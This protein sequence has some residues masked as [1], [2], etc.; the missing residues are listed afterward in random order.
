MMD[1]I[2]INAGNTKIIAHRG[3][4]GIE[5]ENTAAA[6]V[7]AGNRP[8]YFGMENDIHRTADGRFVVF[9]DDNTGNLSPVDI[10]V[11]QTSFSELRRLT[12]THRD[13]RQPVHRGDAV[14]PAFEEYLDICACYG[15]VG[16]VEL[17]SDFTG[18]ELRRI[19]RLCEERDWLK[20]VIFISFKLDCLCRLRQILPEQKMQYLVGER[21]PGLE[22]ILQKNHFGLDARYPIVTREWLEELHRLGIEVNVWTVDD[23]KAGEELCAWGVDYMTSNILEPIR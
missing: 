4:S 8:A 17:K 22:E 16:V 13:G 11:E 9:H 7:A 14:I 20:N 3:L 19:V 15:K 5:V 10:L 23:P 6:F 21:T 2:K 1:T 12:V 18:E